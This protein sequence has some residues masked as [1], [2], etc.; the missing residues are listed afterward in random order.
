MCGHVTGSH[1]HWRLFAGKWHCSSRACQ[2]YSLCNCRN[3]VISPTAYILCYVRS[4]KVV[5]DSIILSNLSTLWMSSQCVQCNF[6][7]SACNSS[8]TATNC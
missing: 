3:A 6:C 8:S 5:D 7:P 2:P 1:L 4:T